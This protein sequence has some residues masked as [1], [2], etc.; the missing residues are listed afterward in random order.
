[1]ADL[2]IDASIAAAWCFKEET[3]GYTD[4]VLIA[5]SGFFAAVAP[6][7]WA[8]EISNTVLI[9]VRRRRITQLHA[10]DFLESIADLRIRLMDYVSYDPVFSLAQNHGLTVY[11]AAYLDLALRE[12]LPLASLDSALCI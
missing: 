11:D 7:L 12:R 4:R 10:G 1:M 5:V 8:Y 3:T 9:G 2:V 6:R